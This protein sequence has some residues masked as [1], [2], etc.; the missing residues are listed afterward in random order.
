[1]PATSA[2]WTG[3]CLAEVAHDAV[4]V[5]IDAAKVEEPKTGITRI[6]APKQGVYDAVLLAVG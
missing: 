6:D 5:E 4:C 2:L 3:T 1:M